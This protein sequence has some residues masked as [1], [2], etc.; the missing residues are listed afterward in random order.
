MG[1][2][3]LVCV[4]TFVDIQ[5]LTRPVHR[6]CCE[7][8]VQEGTHEPECTYRLCMLVQQRV[9]HEVVCK[10]LPPGHVVR[11]SYAHGFCPCHMDSM[12]AGCVWVHPCICSSQEP[13][14]CTHAWCAHICIQ[15][16]TCTH[17]GAHVRLC[18]GPQTG[19]GTWERGVVLRY[20]TMC[21]HAQ[22]RASM[23]QRTCA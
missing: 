22:V 2:M 20:C 4:C 7:W 3:L 15:V 18:M 12:C 21:V 8:G 6:W 9:G 17:G 10:S 11:C 5:G 1:S 16:H 23:G 13:G 19:V 14:G